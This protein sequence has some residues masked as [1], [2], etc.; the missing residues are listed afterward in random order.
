M[1]TWLERDGAEAFMVRE[2]LT[3]PAPFTAFHGLP[4]S[5]E[6]RI[7]A[8]EHRVICEH[9]YWPLD[10]LEDHVDLGT[11]SPSWIAE[12][13]QEMHRS[14][15]AMP[16]LQRMAVEAAKACGG[17]AWSVDFCQDD[18][19]KW[20]LLDMA[21]MQDSYHWPACSSTESKGESV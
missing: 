2:F 21:T 7:F 15:E 10:S 17:S 6:W 14:P 16:D 8:N 9:P 1:K 13:L 3:L 20:W 18:K 11:F 5:R 19:G 12:R 4:I